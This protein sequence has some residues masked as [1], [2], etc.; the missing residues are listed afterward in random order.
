MN[1]DS[2]NFP[3]NARAALGDAHLQDA[4]ERLRGGF[5]ESRRQAIGRLPEF[6]A[7]RD[8]AQLIRTHTLAH[9][10]QYLQ[11]FEERAV[12]AGGH[13]HWCR[14]ADE[15]R[16][17]VLDI[18]RAADAKTV[19]KGK[20][21]IG[22]EIAINEYLQANGIEPVEADLGEYIIQ[23][24][25]EAP[26]H[27]IAPAT[28]LSKEQVAD[29]FRQRHTEL[30]AARSLSEPAELL[31]EARQQLRQKFLAADV[32]ITGA[33]F[34]IAETGTSIIVT[35]EGNGDLTQIL[36]RVHI[37]IASLEK[38]VPSLD[39][40]A[41]LLRVLARSATGQDITAYTTFSTGPRRA[42]DIDGPDAYHVILLDNG[43]TELM[44]G[45]NGEILGCIRC[46]ACLNHCPVYGA[47]GGHAY[48]S[49]Y[50]GPMGSVLTPALKGLKSA[51]HLPQASSLCG[52]CE[53]VCPV[54]LPLPRM[55]RN[56]RFEAAESGAP[57]A[58]ARLL[59]RLWAFSARRPRL[60]HF[61]AGVK[62]AWLAA[63]G[64]R[65]GYLRT[66]PG[67][68]AWTRTWDFPAPEGRTFIAQWKAG[69]R[70]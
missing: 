55:L 38:V 3:A 48:G 50:S 61:G 34:L 11:R 57:G 14:D 6:D 59:V 44:A 17:A 7:L 30:D 41:T 27:I 9:L 67:F 66:I 36:P 68:G 62:L 63:W 60:Y 33:N 45:D 39:D 51:H 64:R 28:H 52:I 69:R 5:V 1:L 26:S 37:V 29:S 22:E 23:L 42:G 12:A 43:R 58:L 25:G 24:R 16:A 15:A 8:R 53:E 35:N 13:V 19:T 65:K 56:L 10:D 4:L 31:A 47:I 20:S 32:G 40:A 46:G 54:R 18:C 2:R 49:V 21:M 70:S